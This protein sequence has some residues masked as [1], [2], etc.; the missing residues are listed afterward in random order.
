MCRNRSGTLFIL[1]N[2]RSPAKLIIFIVD[3]FNHFPSF[4]STLVL[5]LVLGTDLQLTDLPTTSRF[6]FMFLWMKNGGGALLL[7]ENGGSG[8]GD[9]PMEIVSSGEDD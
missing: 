4:N 7:V 2:F 8:G 3:P 1:G 5:V 6:M 9:G